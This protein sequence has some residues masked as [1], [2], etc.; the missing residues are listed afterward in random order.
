MTGTDAG[1]I[2]VLALAWTVAI[3]A[4]TVSR[5]VHLR[6]VGRGRT[7]GFERRAFGGRLHLGFAGIVLLGIVPLLPGATVQAH[8]AAF[9]LGL[10]LFD[11]V[12]RVPVLLPIA[13]GHEVRRGARAGA[14]ARPFADLGGLSVRAA[15]AYGVLWAILIE[16]MTVFGRFG[17]HLES[18][19]STAFLAHFTHGLR[20]HHGYIGVLLLLLVVAGLLRRRRAT[21]RLS[22]VVGV[23]L[24]LSDAVHHF[25]VLLPVTGSPEFHLTY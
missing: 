10:V 5:R 4:L 19:Q 23:A 11:L 16:C 2:L 1:I 22:I 3:Q 25:L 6:T 7:A 12:R 14:P 21:A 13:G 9:A 8:G 15:V 17:F 24:V 20:I 18:Q